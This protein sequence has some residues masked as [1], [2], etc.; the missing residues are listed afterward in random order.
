MFDRSS[1][2]LYQN[3]SY[4]S[5][6]RIMINEKKSNLILRH[7]SQVSLFGVYWG[8]KFKFHTM[9]KPWSSSST[10]VHKIDII[11]TAMLQSSAK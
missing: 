5:K 8:K 9:D 1:L 10:T 6:S 11:A 2:S 7:Q 3:I 4:T